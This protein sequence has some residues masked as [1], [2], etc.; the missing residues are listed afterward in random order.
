[1]RIV[2]IFLLVGL[3][4][5][6]CTLGLLRLL[7]LLLNSLLLLGLLLNPLLLLRLRLSPLLLLRLL[8]LLESGG[9]RPALG[10][11]L[12]RC[13]GRLLR[14]ARL[15]FS[16]C[17]TFGLCLVCGLCGW[18]LGRRTRVLGVFFTRCRLSCG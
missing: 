14:L 12:I 4:S 15:H 2:R 3:F 9:V 18:R 13:L 5:D 11:V 6:R 17:R 10:A 7:R 1:M 16:R 8:L